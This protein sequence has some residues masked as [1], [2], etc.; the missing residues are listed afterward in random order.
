MQEQLQNN[1]EKGLNLNLQPEFQPEGTY[2][3]ALNAYKS[4]QPVGLLNEEGNELCIDLDGYEILG[5]NLL[6]HT[7]NFIIFLKKL[8]LL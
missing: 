7:N 4:M 2:R 5:N 3:F 6:L 1:L 8:T